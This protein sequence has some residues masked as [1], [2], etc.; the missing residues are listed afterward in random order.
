VAA[1]PTGTVTLVFTDIEGST[2]LLDEL[3]TNLYRDAL[4]EHRRIV[5]EAFALFEGYEVDYEGDAFFY[6]FASAQ[7]AVD[8]VTEAMRGLEAGP[9]RIRV[10]I[11]TGEPVPDPPK[12]V[13][14]DVH[15]A[16]RVM[17]AGHG[18][19]VLL[20][21][22]TQ[23]HVNNAVQDLGEHRLKDFAESVSILQ[24]GEGSFPPLKTISNTN[25]PRPAS[26]FVGREREVGDV[27]ALVRDGARIVT[28]TGPGG[29][30]KTR[31]GIESAAELVPTF[32]AGVFWVGLATLRDPGLV[33]ETIAQEL[34][35]RGELSEHIGER[36]ML[37][38]LDNLEQVVDAAS[39]LASLVEACPNLRLLV[40]SRELMR[41]RGEVEYEVLPLAEPDAVE[42]FCARA[43][44]EPGD[45]VAELCRHLDD[46][47]LALELA[48]SRAR[49]LTP[50]Q[51]LE[52]L[53]QRLDLLQGGRDADP[54]Q[55]TLRATIAWSHDLLT[56]A[57]QQLFARLSVFVG[58]CT[59]EAAEKVCDADLD[60]LQSLVEKSLVR[61]TAERLWMLETIREFAVERLDESGEGAVTADRRAGWLSELAEAAAPTTMGALE[62][63]TYDV[64]EAEHANIRAVVEH[65]LANDEHT[66]VFL[67]ARNLWPFWITRG[68]TKEAL[69]WVEKAL[70]A[71]DAPVEARAY[72]VLAAS[73][74]ARFAGALDRAIALKQQ[75]LEFAQEGIGEDWWAAGAL[76][77]LGEIALMRGDPVRA[78]SYGQQSLDLI[79][80]GGNPARASS[81]LGE[82]ALAEGDVDGAV[83][84]F[85]EAAAGWQ[86][87]HENNYAAALEGLAEAAR[88][89]GDDARAT[90]LFLDAL[91]R[92]VRLGDEAAAAECLEGLAAIAA[93]RG[94]ANRAARLCGGAAV[95]RERSGGMPW[96]KRSELDGLSELSRAEGAGLS[97]E[98]ALAYARRP[99]D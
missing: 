55:Q 5:R 8:A 68:H 75:T 29:S 20:T 31:L 61:R 48:A 36:E 81:V 77:D 67:L 23:E 70:E 17:S 56:P 79:G 30:G 94:D 37:L 2:R 47:P 6:A 33:L 45:T 46:L 51:I 43:Q 93:D 95:L 21:R 92:F 28:L 53:S 64:L 69:S 41:V 1:Q 49:I 44:V 85:E 73:E 57:E 84:L 27:L 96:R 91:E 60:T 88:R 15:K 4:G 13:G 35:A 54:R 99:T 71:N 59:L 62:A 83:H 32:R 63:A 58:G 22:A 65:A 50:D 10:G 66:L 39:E 80:S 16:A 14:T 76:A 72:A 78:R 34:G 86:G 82:V 25:L 9:I 3:G 38:L 89:K 40:T 90:A 52:R 42:L 18:G 98:E 26:S 19:Q 11:H 24:L 7:A 87:R 97:L 12:Y 74:L